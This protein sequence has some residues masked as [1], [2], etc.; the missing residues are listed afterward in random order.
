YFPEDGAKI[1]EMDKRRA[2]LKPK[3]SPLKPEPLPALTN[4]P[5]MGPG[6]KTIYQVAGLLGVSVEDMLSPNRGRKFAEARCLA[7]RLLRERNP[8]VYSFPRLAKMLGGKDKSTIIYAWQNFDVF[9]KRNPRVF[10]A[11]SELGGE[12]TWEEATSA[13]S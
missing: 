6:K 7:V 5:S 2:E 4:P 12:M 3:K 10:D 1:K 13:T 9:V 11:Y 8:V